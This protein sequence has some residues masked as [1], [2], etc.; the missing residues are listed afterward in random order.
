MKT[1]LQ[2]SFF[3]LFATQFCFAQCYQ[4]NSGTNDSLLFFQ[5]VSEQV[6]WASS[7][8]RIF[9]TSDGGVNWQPKYITP[10]QDS[11]IWR[12]F[13]INENIGWKF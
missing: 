4:Q 13:F 5:F 12:M 8:H 10:L 1:F 3:I 9:K 2:I 11:I 7:P 6:G